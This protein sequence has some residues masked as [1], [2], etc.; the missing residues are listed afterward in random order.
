MSAK[1]SNITFTC[2]RKELI[3]PMP[4]LIKGQVN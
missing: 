4:R 1:S 3:S 2:I